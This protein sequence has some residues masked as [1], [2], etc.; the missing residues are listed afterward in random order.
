LRPELSQLITR[1]S[2]PRSREFSSSVATQTR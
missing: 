2:R 1:V